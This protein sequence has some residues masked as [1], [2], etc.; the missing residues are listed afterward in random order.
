[1]MHAFVTYHTIKSQDQNKMSYLL[2]F[3]LF[4]VC[5]LLNQYSVQATVF[6]CNTTAPCGC[7]INKANIN[8]RI[9]GGE[10]SASHSW[11]WAVSL[12]VLTSTHFCGGSIISPHYVLTAAHCVD[13]PQITR[14]QITAA[15]GT[16]TL[17]D[18]YGQRI[19]VSKIYK[20]PGWN[21]VTK[22]ND[23]A[24][25]K[26]S[27]AISFK[28]KNIAKLCLP[29]LTE[30]KD[31]DFPWINTKLVAIGWGSTAS[32]GSS[33]NVLRQVTIAAVGDTETKCSNSI[34]NTRVQF[35][36]AVDGGGK[37]N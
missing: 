34:Y 19:V 21:S 10:P 18:T 7:S 26:L 25:L 9:V 13:D 36:A 14:L 27:N 2:K 32:G 37:G 12:R 20:H 17:Y 23:I 1:M 3:L 24:L 6:A 8:A 31:V 5:V 35:C 29:S 30:Y 33:S 4:I 11:G 15:V 16:D 28:D 22:E